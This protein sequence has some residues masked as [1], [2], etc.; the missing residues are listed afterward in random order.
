MNYKALS[1]ILSPKPNAK[2]KEVLNL[3]KVGQKYKA[4]YEIDEEDQGWF[5]PPQTGTIAMNWLTPKDGKNHSDF[6]KEPYIMNNFF[7][8][9]AAN[10]SID[11]NETKNFKI[12]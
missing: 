2:N 1:I 7:V 5:I 10:Y 3:Y 4:F 6:T 9:K 8:M 12:L 11:E